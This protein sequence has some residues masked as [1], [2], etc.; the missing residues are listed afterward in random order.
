VNV[1]ILGASGF[2]GRHAAAAIE[3]AGHA[4][5]RG[6]RA[7]F[8]FMSDRPVEQWIEQL[9]AVSVEAVVNAVGI[10]RED[11]AASFARV[12]TATPIAL[13][14]ACAALRIPVVQISALGADASA[15]TSFLLSKKAADDAL[16]A[17]DVPSVVLMPSL[18]YGDDGRSAAMFRMLA[19]LPLIPLPA[20]GTQPIQPVHVDDVA[21]AIAAII[22]ARRF[23]R[24]RMPIVGPHP[25]A[26][27]DYLAIL[28][29]AMGLRRARFATVPIRVANAAAALRIGLLDR[30][31]LAMLERGSTGDPEPITSLLGGAPRAVR[32]FLAAEHASSLRLVAQWQWLRPLLRWTV[33]I[34]WLA[35][36]VVS[37]RLY[38]IADSLALIART[39]ITGLPAYVALYGASALDVALGLAT[40]AIGRL[41]RAWRRRVW[42]LQIGVI[43]LYTAI[44]TVFLPGQWLHPYGPVVKNLPLLAA[45]LLLHETER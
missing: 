14:Q 15:T 3:A 31:A 35:A 25:L 18:V 11:S 41:P 34:V 42:L 27:R 17:L 1:L 43:V 29:D 8:D 12:H 40:L 33:G 39:H 21:D 19:T 26:L 30:D 5:V 32:S 13:F 10:F 37:A 45:I 2:I 44:I 23:E 7:R 36:G 20:G 28:R 16:L 24:A 38:P 22:A 6:G 4:V 9:A